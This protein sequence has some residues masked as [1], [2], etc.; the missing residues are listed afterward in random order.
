MQNAG[1]SMLQHT[2][3]GQKTTFGNQFSTWV[4]GIKTQID[5]RRV[6]Q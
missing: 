1:V 4:Q 6:Q 5:I 3:E 2:H